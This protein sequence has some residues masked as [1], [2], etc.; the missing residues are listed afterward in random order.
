LAGKS[1]SALTARSAAK[2]Y[3]IDLLQLRD[4]TS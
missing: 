3:R 4:L 1:E 2:T